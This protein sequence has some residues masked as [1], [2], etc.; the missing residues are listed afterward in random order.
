MET[1]NCIIADDE[2]PARDLLEHFIAQTPG[3]HLA[4]SFRNGAD[5]LAFLESH[6][7]DLIFLDITMP[8]ISGLDMIRKLYHPPPYILTTAHQEFAVQAFELNA[9]DYLVKPFSLERFQKAVTRFITSHTLPAKSEIFLTISINRNKVQVPV[10]DI[11]YIQASGN[12]CRIYLAN[13]KV[14]LSKN[15]ITAI[16]QQL[17]GK[18]FVQVHRSFIVARSKIFSSTANSL[19]INGKVLPIGRNYKEQMNKE[20]GNR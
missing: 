18:S 19:T 8:G 9:I 10:E 12:Y 20:Q 1:V 2:K 7:P 4:G 6:T 15:T 11:L 17:P 16:G 3:L 14:L 5:V 13:E